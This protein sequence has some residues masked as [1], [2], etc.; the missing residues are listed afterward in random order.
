ML[1][2]SEEGKKIFNSLSDSE[3]K[4][5]VGIIKDLIKKITDWIDELLQSYNSKSE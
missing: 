1:K 3:K 2:M 4:S 5:L